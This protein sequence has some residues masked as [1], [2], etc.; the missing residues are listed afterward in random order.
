MA[1]G[2]TTGGAVSLVN[3]MYFDRPVRL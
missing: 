2:S 1:L 3:Y